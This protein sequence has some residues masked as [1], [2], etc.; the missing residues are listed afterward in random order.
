[1][2][3]AG[4]PSSLTSSIAAELAPPEAA[5]LKPFPSGV[6][7]G[8]LASVYAEHSAK[9]K[10]ATA[11]LQSM[12]KAEPERFEG[13]WANMAV[14]LAEAQ[15]PITS[16]QALADPALRPLVL[17]YFS[18]PVEFENERARLARGPEGGSLNFPSAKSPMELGVLITKVAPDYRRMLRT[19][20]K[21]LRVTPEIA[22][23][24]TDSVGSGYLTWLLAGYMGRH[25]YVFDVAQ[26]AFIPSAGPI[27]VGYAG[28]N[29]HYLEVTWKARE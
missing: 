23:A 17:D 13:S 18:D 22:Q 7:L 11:R 8:R 29:Y 14:G 26:N 24:V 19:S 5:L 20:A 9:A 25:G 4:L 21:T 6:D 15:I 27:D 12:G 1:M 2:I 3:V 28:Q 16:A 10:R